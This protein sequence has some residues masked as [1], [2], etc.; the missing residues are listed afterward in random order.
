MNNSTW[1]TNGWKDDRCWSNIFLATTLKCWS[2]NAIFIYLAYVN[3]I[4]FKDYRRH[5]TKAVTTCVIAKVEL[6]L[7][8]TVNLGTNIL[9]LEDKQEN[10]LH[11]IKKVDGIWD[12]LL[13][14]YVFEW[15]QSLWLFLFWRNEIE[16]IF[17]FLSNIG[18]YQQILSWSWQTVITFCDL[19]NGICWN[20]SE[21]VYQTILWLVRFQKFEINIK[22]FLIELQQLLCSSIPS[23]ST[24]WIIKI[25]KTNHLYKTISPQLS[26][27]LINAYW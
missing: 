20:I 18:Q 17:H 25:W 13:I 2:I 6:N 10:K 12:S 1:H 11:L 21:A 5:R 7:A 4:H 8:D 9:A 23:L 16:I 3:Q 27:A 15:K 19:W 24:W 26:P 22:C 14:N